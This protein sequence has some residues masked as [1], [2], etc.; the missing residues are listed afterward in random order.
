[1]P[2]YHATVGPTRAYL[3][4]TAAS[5]VTRRR[6]REPSW[7]ALDA[8]KPPLRLA[9]GRDAVDTI[10]GQLE[11]LTAELSEWE[12]VSRDTASDVDT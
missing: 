4:P 6:P 3:A 1:M 5:S 8:P 9:L 7:A 10:R 12:A 2:E 11:S